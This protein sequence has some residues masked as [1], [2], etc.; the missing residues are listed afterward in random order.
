VTIK[1]AKKQNISLNPSKISGMCGRLMCCLT[2]EHE[3][4]EKIKKNFPKIGKRILTHEGE[5]KTIR[6]NVLKEPVTV[7]LDSGTEL[8]IPVKDLPTGSSLSKEG[9]FKRKKPKKE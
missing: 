5:G 3:Y 2:F 6:Q 8:E 4:Y 7:A 9:L 1:M